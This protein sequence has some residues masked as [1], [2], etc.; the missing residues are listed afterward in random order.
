MATEFQGSSKG[1]S[2][3]TNKTLQLAGAS[4]ENDARIMQSLQ[5]V[6]QIGRLNDNTAIQDA[7]NSGDGL[8]ALSKFS[9]TLGD[10]LIKDQQ[11]KNLREYEEGI[12][13]AYFNGVSPEESAEFDAG[14]ATV[15]SVGRTT[16]E[17]GIEFAETTGDR[18]GGEKISDSSGWRSLGRATGVAKQGANNYPAF[19]A[20]MANAEIN[21]VSLSQATTQEEY[22]VAMDGIRNQFLQQFGGMSRGLM[23]KYLFPS[24]HKQEN[25]SFLDWQN[26]NNNRIESDRMTE[27]GDELYADASGG[28][29]GKGFIDFIQKN[30]AFLGGKGN[31]RKKAM[32]I[33]KEGVASGKISQEDVD[34]MREHTFDFNGSYKTIGEI[35]GRDFDALEDAVKAENYQSYT[36]Q[37]QEE[38]IAKKGIIDNIRAAQKELGR[39]WT[40]EE[41]KE[42][43]RNW[44]NELGE[45]PAEL[46]NLMTQ[47]KMEAEDAKDYVEA[48][49]NNGYKLTEEDLEGIPANQRQNYANFMVGSGVSSEQAGRN[50]EYIKSL[51]NDIKNI[52]DGEAPKTPEWNN[53]YDN[54]TAVFEQRL[55]RNLR[56]MSTDEAIAD[57]RQFVTNQIP[58]ISDKLPVISQP[59]RKAT[60]ISTA[61][62]ALQDNPKMYLYTPLP[63]SED[64]LKEL[65]TE[66]KHL[67]KFYTEVA[68]GMKNM[69]GWDLAQ[70]QAE[71]AGIK[72]EVPEVEEVMSAEDIQGLMKYQPSPS[73][74]LRVM[75][76]NGSGNA[77]LDMMSTP[78]SGGDYNAFNT[79]GSQGGEVAH[80][81]GFGDDAS[82]KYGKP[83]TSMSVGEVMALGSSNTNWIWA[84]GRYQIIPPTLKGLVSNYGIDKNLPF[85]EEM[86]NNLALLLAY[87]RLNSGQGINGLRNEWIG[88]RKVPAE[89]IQASLGEAYNNPQ[90]LLKGV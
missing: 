70:Q 77:F 12:A 2:F 20:S 6:Q 71:L 4:K 42:I 76:G 21:G 18:A 32:E 63:G 10:K 80:G 74:A 90:V 34:A 31:A 64:A 83:L 46:N 5:G 36:Q 43:L 75:R 45:P 66:P 41:K 11:S 62:R 28:N 16:D 30:E 87:E 79:G 37:V 58:N 23:A 47:E 1:G 72:L 3:R 89:V 84:A 59:G 38:T 22:A 35:F 69:S 44:P 24:M 85:D 15:N 33:L 51:V 52:Q 7:K 39:E 48:R 65:E 60:Q 8:I 88:L 54:T 53:L 40:D 61:T 81:S 17:L 27:M 25:A 73:K 86:Q 68:K 67:P 13:D 26:D 78:E 9:K 49:I 19:V 29:G 56:T 55:N 50:K 57:A 82:N 14:E